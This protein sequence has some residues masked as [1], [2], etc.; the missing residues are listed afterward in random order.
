M[1]KRILSTTQHV[2]CKP[3]KR[4]KHKADN[5]WKAQLVDAID[6]VLM[7]DPTLIYGRND[8]RYSIQS[9]IGI[10]NKY[11]N[12]LTE[13]HLIETFDGYEVN[14]FHLLHVL[15]ISGYNLLHFVA[16]NLNIKYKNSTCISRGAK[17]RRTCNNIKYALRTFKYGEAAA[18][19][20]QACV[21]GVLARKFMHTAWLSSDHSTIPMVICKLTNGCK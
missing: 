15:G 5:E 3:T 10:I 9:M 11:G 8:T 19:R 1:A 6:N 12:E 16:A 4:S 20:I 18:T 17:I 21:R 14:R 13:K 2:S 7:V